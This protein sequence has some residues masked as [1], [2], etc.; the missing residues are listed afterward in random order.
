MGRV[1]R[2]IGGDHLGQR[3][4]ADSVAGYEL[5]GLKWAEHRATSQAA[6]DLHPSSMRSWSREDSC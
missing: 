4:V 6:A 3:V 2:K 1:R 5:T